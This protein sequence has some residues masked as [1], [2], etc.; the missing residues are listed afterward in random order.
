MI[1]PEALALDRPL[2][3]DGG[4]GSELRRR[5]IELSPQCWS[6]AANVDR[7]DVVEAIHRDYMEAGANIVTANTFGTTRF[8]L[9]AA[10]LDHRFDEINGAAIRAAQRAAA[11]SDHPV[12]VAASLSCLPP[13]FDRTAYP[14]AD[15][16]YRAYAELTECFARRQVDLVLAEMLQNPVHTAR[17][18]R[19]ARH[20][21]L[22][23]IAGISC[24]LQ[25]DRLVAFDEPRLSFTAMLDAVL[26][27]EPAA[28]AI[29]HTPLAAMLPALAALRTEWKGCVAAYAEIPY[30]QNPDDPGGEPVSP[31]DYAAAARGWVAAGATIVGGCCGTTPAHIAALRA[32]SES[33][34]SADS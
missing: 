6:G 16:E 18:L 15:A 12:V 14:S 34:A 22:P 5:G 27:F 1:W 26:P 17:A 24:R 11:D 4:V 2:V 28:I 3:L 10:G 20:C 9:A 30:P 21:G 32:L 29:M 33:G 8:V 31:A 7:A 23:F 25:D 19:A 13:A